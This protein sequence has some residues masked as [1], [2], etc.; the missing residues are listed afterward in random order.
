M[1]RR[2]GESLRRLMYGRYGSDELNIALLIAAVAVSL[3]NS[4]LSLFLR[5]S[6]VYTRVVSPILYLV[7]LGLLGFSLF[8]TFS[9]NIY[10]RQ[11]ENR[12]FRRQWQR[13]RDRKNRYFRCPKCRQTVRVPKG[14]GKISIHCPKCGERFIKKT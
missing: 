13:L 6:F 5:I 14:K 8:R 12:W 7:M 10:A 4:I 1:F 11:K 9:R 2:F 3:I